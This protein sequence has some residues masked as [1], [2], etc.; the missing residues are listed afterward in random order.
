LEGKEKKKT[1]KTPRERIQEREKD[2][3]RRN[4]IKKV[5]SEITPHTDIGSTLV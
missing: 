1:S 5:K 3:E 2:L 4:K